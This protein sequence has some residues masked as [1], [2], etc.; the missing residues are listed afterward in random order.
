M[1]DY[2]ETRHFYETTDAWGTDLYGTYTPAYIRLFITQSLDALPITEETKILNA[3]S[4]GTIYYPKGKQY[5]LDL[6]EAK[7]A[8]LENA[9]VGNVVDMPFPD[10]FFDIVLLA[11][12]VISYCEADK[13]L[14]EVAR[15]LKPGGR[16]IVDYERSESVAG[17]FLTL[18]RNRDAVEFSYEY[19]GKPHRST[20]Y[21][22]RYILGLLEDNHLRIESS[23]RFHSTF[24]MLFWLPKKTLERL[25]SRDLKV[26]NKKLWGKLA[27]NHILMAE[28]Q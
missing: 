16:L 27:H 17:R 13:A 19:E 14:R 15:V 5:H 23:M 9:V 2:E 10:G 22:D 4:G 3:G 18:F 1:V 21:S 8:G 20:F 26:S 24:S 25:Y 11:G 7:L 12:C 6:V 28:K